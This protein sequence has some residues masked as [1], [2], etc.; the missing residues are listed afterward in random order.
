MQLEIRASLHYTFSFT[1]TKPSRSRQIIY[2][3]SFV[4]LHQPRVETSV[5][6]ASKVSC[7]SAFAKLSCFSQIGK[8]HVYA[9]YNISDIFGNVGTSSKTVKGQVKVWDFVYG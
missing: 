3:F 1:N 5:K 4:K 8:K 2:C 6:L 7:F 9:K